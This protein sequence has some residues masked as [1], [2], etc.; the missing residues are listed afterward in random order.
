MLRHLPLPPEQA[1]SPEF[2]LFCTAPCRFNSCYQLKWIYYCV[3]GFG[4]WIPSARL[5]WRSKDLSW[6][7][8]RIILQREI[9]CQSKQKIDRWI[10]G[11]QQSLHLLSTAL[12][13]PYPSL[14]VQTQQQFVHSICRQHLTIIQTM[15]CMILSKPKR[16]S[17]FEEITQISLD[18]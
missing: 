3:L 10:P 16:R 7:D 14:Q 9:S 17:R 15:V 13:L 4:L 6:I 5:L 1:V 8:E 11:L 12:A 18:V 2:S